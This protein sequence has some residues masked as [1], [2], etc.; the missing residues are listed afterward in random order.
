MNLDR[1]GELSFLHLHNGR[2]FTELGQDVTDELLGLFEE[3]VLASDS[4]TCTDSQGSARLGLVDPQP[5]TP[6]AHERSDAKT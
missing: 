1:L 6:V 2:L 3:P 4:V 5:H